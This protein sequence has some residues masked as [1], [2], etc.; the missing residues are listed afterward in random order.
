MSRASR[1]GYSTESSVISMK[2]RYLPL[3]LALLALASCASSGKT[4]ATAA[5]TAQTQAASD[6]QLERIN[7]AVINI[8]GMVQFYQQVF[9]MKF[10]KVENLGAFLYEGKLFGLDYLLIPND[11]L[12]VRA[13]QGRYQL[14]IKVNDI[15]AVVGR[16]VNVGGTLKAGVRR[17]DNMRVATVFDPD[18]N[19]LTFIQPD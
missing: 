6:F 11:I 3:L 8:E 17:R 2:Q 10:K 18:G 13:E 12:G 19:T 15:D 14:D 16:A 9:N 7:F 1:A 5:D 4:A